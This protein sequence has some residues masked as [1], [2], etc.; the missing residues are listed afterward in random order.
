MGNIP[1]KNSNKWFKDLLV[2][3]PLKKMTGPQVAN[4]LSEA[5]A[6]VL[7]IAIGFKI[8]GYLLFLGFVFIVFYMIWCHKIS[9]PFRKK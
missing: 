3:L 5:L 6:I 7:L 4:V 1:N 2:H 8:E 9:C